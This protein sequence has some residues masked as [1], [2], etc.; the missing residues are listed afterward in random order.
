[1]MA[2]NPL[3]GIL[4]HAIDGFAAG[5]FY[6]PLK[7]IRNISWESAWL[8]MGLAA[9]LAAPWIAAYL[10][11]PKLGEVVSE[12]LSTQWEAVRLAVF[13]GFLWGFGNLTYGMAARYL[14]IAL[15]GS[16]AL[17]FCMIFGTL[18]PPY[19][20]GTLGDLIAKPSGWAILGGIAIC[21]LGIALCGEAGRRRD[22]ELKASADGASREEFRFGLG[23]FVAVVAGILSACFAIGLDHG[24]PIATIALSKGVDPLY[25]NNSILIAVLLGGFAS[26]ALCCLVMNVRK[27]SFGDYVRFNG[28]YF[29]NLA[30]VW[31]AGVTWF[32]QFFFYGMGQSKLGE[33][34]EFSSWSI[35]M[36]FIVVFLNLWGLVFHEW[37]GTSQKTKSLVWV[38]ILI[39][40]ASTIVIG[41]GNKLAVSEGAATPAAVE[42]E[43]P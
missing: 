1:M 31:L 36:A 30:L 33:Q 25:K 9:W 43:A 11:T 23:L 17:A 42:I 41:V 35:H 34:F 20:K 5:S 12:S 6:S 10:T 38:G 14:G 2:P 15:G 21:T 22:L 29:R 26:N 4:L 19:R 24:A 39:L 27:G 13:F 28:E 37:R 18:E 8:L 40:I 7:K 16:I 3:L 32:F